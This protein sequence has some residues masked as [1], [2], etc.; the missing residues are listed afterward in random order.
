MKRLLLLILSIFFIGLL[1][2]CSDVGSV[3]SLVVDNNSSNMEDNS[4]NSGITQPDIL[5]IKTLNGTYDIEFY[6]ADLSGFFVLTNDCLLIQYFVLNGTSCTNSE[7][8][9]VQLKGDGIIK[10]FDNGSVKV[11]TKIQMNGGIFQGAAGMMFPQNRYIFNDYKLIPA[12]A[13]SDLKINDLST[14]NSVK[15]IN[16][17]YADA[18]IVYNNHEAEISDGAGSSFELEV[19]SDGTIVSTVY[20]TSNYIASNVIIRMKKK[21]DNIVELDANTPYETPVIDNFNSSVIYEPSE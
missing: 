14:G 19:L 13:V 8:D 20:D 16:G 21:S 18:L 10:V 3:T 15:G 5:D 4:Q 2:A 1:S 17:R 12:N 7:S 11:Q 9:S 6:Y